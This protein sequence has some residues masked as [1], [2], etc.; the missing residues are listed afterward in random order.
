[1]SRP[2]RLKSRR[3][4]VFVV[5][6]PAPS[7]IR[8]IQRARLWAITCAASQAALAANLPGWQVIEPDAVLEI[9]DRVLDLGVAPMIGLERWVLDAL[10]VALATFAAEYPDAPRA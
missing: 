1:V 7:P 8:A 3:R 2:A 9:A 10:I 6:I 5:T 4:R